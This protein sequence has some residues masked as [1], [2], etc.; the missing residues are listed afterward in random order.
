M[1][2]REK[3]DAASAA[4]FVA[5]GPG[6]YLWNSGM[7]LWRASR[8][9][10]L[11]GRYEPELLAAVSRIASSA[12]GPGFAAALALAY[13]SIKKISVDYGVMEPA[14]KDPDVLIAALPL[15][16]EWLD[17]GSWPAYGQLLP[18]D[19]AGNA[20]AG[21]SVLVESRGNVVVSTQAGHLVA[22]LGCEELVVVHTPDATLV[23][24]KS[25]A[26]ELKK[27]YAA[28]AAIESGKYR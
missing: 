24:P 9:L 8:F 13:P 15:A 28:A 10:E 21:E 19:A 14:S 18:R 3:P 27:L 26:D 16:I 25:K 20:T 11:V 22:C 4:S 17:V 2:F 7:F 6:R 1:R 23:C 12:G 5:A